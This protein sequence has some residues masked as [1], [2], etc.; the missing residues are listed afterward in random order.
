MGK[1]RVATIGVRVLSSV[2]EPVGR[3]IA[4]TLEVFF[5]PVVYPNVDAYTQS[6]GKENGRLQ[7]VHE[8]WHPRTNPI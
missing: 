4:E 8:I 7:S 6:F 3:F 2:A 1:L 5:E